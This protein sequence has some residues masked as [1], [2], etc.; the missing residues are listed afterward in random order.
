MPW[1]SGLNMIF[2]QLQGSTKDVSLMLDS[3]FFNN[4]CHEI[5]NINMDFINCTLTNYKLW[6]K[7]DKKAKTSSNQKD[8]Y[9]DSFK[10]F[11]ITRS[12]LQSKTIGELSMYI[13]GASASFYDT[14]INGAKQKE[15]VI[16]AKQSELFFTYCNFSQ[17]VVY[18]NT[19]AVIMIEQ[20]ES[21]IENCTFTENIG[22]GRGIIYAYKSIVNITASSFE[23]NQASYNSGGV[24]YSQKAATITILNSIFKSNKAYTGG[25]IYIRYQTSIY[26]H[27]SFFVN[28]RARNTGGVL[29]GYFATSLTIERTQFTRNTMGVFMIFLEF[30]FYGE[31]YH[32][33]NQY[34]FALFFVVK[35]PT[36]YKEFLA[37]FDI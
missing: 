31:I 5:H 37:Y 21:V 7:G 14:E 35:H 33:N 17:N 28:N 23:R 9:D 3:V 10:C 12:K 30:L 15:P 8:I 2:D 20:S 18:Y 4:S 1:L 16:T 29:Y 22:H 24:I 36:N 26:I 19:H 27:G 13:F 25:V 32:T 11:S 6:F 34:L